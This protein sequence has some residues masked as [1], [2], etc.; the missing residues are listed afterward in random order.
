MR[1]TDLHDLLRAVITLVNQQL[2][3]SHVRVVRNLHP[4]LPLVA[5]I[6]SHLKQVYISLILNAIESMPEGGVLNIRTYVTRDEDG[7]EEPLPVQDDEHLSAQD[8]SAISTNMTVATHQ[9]THSHVVIE[10]SDTGRGIPA[11]ELT[12]VF[13]PFYTTRSNGV[14]LSLAI[15]YGIVEQHNG[16][17]TVSSEL[18]RGTTFRVSI[19]ALT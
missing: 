5:G 2:H 15:S 4:R 11:E 17:L 19:P 1:P 12:K 18:G 7:R 8:M 10:F 3:T 13:E 6:S 16:K 9:S 14:G